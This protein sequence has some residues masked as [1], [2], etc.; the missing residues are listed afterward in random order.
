MFMLVSAF[1]LGVASVLLCALIYMSGFSDGETCQKKKIINNKP[2]ITPPEYTLYS[3][4]GKLRA[5][6]KLDPDTSSDN[7]QTKLME[8]VLSNRLSYDSRH[9]AYVRT[10]RV[11]KII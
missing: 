9:Q 2:Y 7:E 8:D 11:H 1:V 4:K 3:A 5:L 6:K 10:K